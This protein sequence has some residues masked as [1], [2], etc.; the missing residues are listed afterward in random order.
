MDQTEEVLNQ[1][2][3]SDNSARERLT[4]LV[5]LIA[6]IVLIILSNI[7]ILTSHL[8]REAKPFDIR[9]V[10]F[11]TLHTVRTFFPF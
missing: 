1:L 8:F 6:Y 11:H 7:C 5:G 4:T 9:L 10:F 3:Q 2:P